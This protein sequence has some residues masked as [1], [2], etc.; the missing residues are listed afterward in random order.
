[1]L[2]S[3]EPR[4]RLS[5]LLFG[6]LFASLSTRALA[7]ESEGPREGEGAVPRGAGSAVVRKAPD[8]GQA[9][10]KIEMPKLVKYVD[11]VYPKEAEEQGL[12]AS[13]VLTLQIDKTGKVT[14]VE[15]TEPVGHG[16]DEAA[17][18][19]AMQ[20]E[21]EPATRDGKPIPVKINYRYNFTLKEVEK[22][23][24]EQKPP[25]VGNLGGTIL[26]SG[27]EVPLAAAE[28]VVTGPNGAAHR[29]TTDAQG[30][31]T[32]E[33][34]PPGK[35]EV[36]VSSGGFDPLDAEEDVAAGEATDVK[37]RLAPTKVKGAIEVTVQGERPQR[38]VTRRTIERRE[39][40][41]VPGTSGDAL[42]SIQALPGVARPPGFAGLLIV[43]GSAPQDTSTFV[44]G[45]PVPLIYHFGGLTSVF[46]T[47]LLDRI[48]FYPGNFSA[49][50]GQYMGGIVDVGLR[51]PNT[52]CNGDYSTP[53]DK[54]GCFHGLVQADLID[55]RALVQGPIGDWKF[56]V[57]GRRSWVDAWLGPVLEQAGA[58]VTTAPV[59]YDY[60]VIADNKPSPTSHISL[61][62]YGSDDRLKVLISNPAA[63]EPAFAGGLTFGTSFYRAQAVYQADLSRHIDLSAMVAVGGNSADLSLGPVAFDLS[64]FSIQT[65]SELS[66]KIANGFKLHVGLDYLVAPYDIFIRAPPPPRPG[67]PSPGPFTT[68]PLLETQ[69]TATA[70]RPAWYTEAELQP[71]RRALVVPGFR[72][73]YA[74]DTGHVDLSPRINGRYDLVGGHVEDELPPEERHLRTTLKGGVGVFYQ[75]PQFQETNPVFGTPGLLS[76]RSIHYSVG[77]EQELSSQVEVSVEAYYKDLTNL[78][79]RQESL[80]S[81]FMYDNAGTGSVIGLETLLKYKPD[82]RF[83]GWLTYTLSRSVRRDR[84]DQAEYLFQYDQ[85]HIFQVLGSYRLGRGWEF[86]ARYRVISGF[87]T[88]PVL[89]PP[90]LPALYASDAGTYTPLQGAPFSRRLPL[91][92]QL[93]VRID[94]SWQFKDWRF[95][96]YLDVVNAYNYASRDA[97]VYNYNYTAQAYQTGLPIIP[98]LGFRGEF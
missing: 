55:T 93:D 3:R 84:P 39:M 33:N 67:E 44:D 21:F 57:A 30:K 86:G 94:K 73:D 66:F 68:R 26:I 8:E 92:H 83:F 22:K 75:P 89:Q 45:T 29:T 64:L 58:S 53:T 31:W 28:V 82:K 51:E 32:V 97:L 61:R 34:V 13:V 24:E 12:A 9:A 72:I 88:T 95:S 23:A 41:R 14:Q 4:V 6:L 16:F 25:T 77:V 47:E 38:E 98:S 15:V 7:Q 69:Q 46:P 65:K 5:S 27:V 40:E 62:F 1:M 85:T 18:Q 37:Y 59:Y 80:G 43:R 52:R 79:S 91:F 20:L 2:V 70:Y 63:Q 78:V 60:Q 19:A 54:Y 71:T 81:L 96:T 56:A 87:L 74:R 49:R 90:G 76:N 36:H 42:R 35:Y 50:Y 48:D 11:P 10:P 17:Q